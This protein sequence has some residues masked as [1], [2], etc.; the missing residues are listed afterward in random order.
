[1]SDRGKTCLV[2]DK[3]NHI[4]GNCYSVRK[5][6]IDIHQY[7]PHI[8]HTNSQELWNYINQFGEFFAYRHTVKASS[9]GQLYS[10]P[11]NL[12]TLRQVFGTHS[13]SH[14]IEMMR[15]DREPYRDFPQD[16]VEDWC[17]AN[18]GPTLYR[19]F[20]QGYT[21]KVWRKSPR[22]MDASVVKRL[23]FRDV[24]D[25]NYYRHRYQGIP[26]GGYTR[27]FEN[28][29]RGVEVRLNS[30]YFRDRE[31]WD[32]QADRIVYTG[33]MDRF[34]D[35]KHG[36]L[37]WRSLRFVSST[38]EPYGIQEFAQ[39]NYTDEAVPYIRSVEYRHL[40][41]KPP[42]AR[43]VSHIVREFPAELA[44]TGEAYYPVQTAA[45]RRRYAYYSDMA[46]ELGHQYVFGG[47]LAKY[48]YI[49][50]APTIRM[51]LNT[52]QRE[53]RIQSKPGEIHVI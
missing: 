44:E 7:G 25:D 34:F 18:I 11:I 19:K 32:A 28:M 16:N 35:F 26:L 47:R 46:A 6:G 17:L 20:I 40:M 27:V 10:F 8:F 13:N 38:H 31:Y 37:E 12:A 15:T 36:R 3:R 14:A 51:A 5:D 49:D 42:Q 23:P 2:I 53:T 50:M 21:K 41:H 48:V 9:N 30:D 33:N 52:V 43:K 1:M 29:L 45:N 22:E 4:E 24:E 39:I